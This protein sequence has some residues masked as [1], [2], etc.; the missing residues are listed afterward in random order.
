MISSLRVVS[1]PKILIPYLNATTSCGRSRNGPFPE[2]LAYL[3]KPGILTH[4]VIVQDYISQLQPVIDVY[5][6]GLAVIE[7]LGKSAISGPRPTIYL[8]YISTKENV[9][10]HH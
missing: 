1:E 5:G 7:E 4:P 9:W 3:Y 8:V 6:I 2:M 10:Y